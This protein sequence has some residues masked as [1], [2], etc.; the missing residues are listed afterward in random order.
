MRFLLPEPAGTSAAGGE[1]NASL[2]EQGGAG[3][4]VSRLLEMLCPG[5]PGREV[6]NEEENSLTE[7]G[8]YP[9]PPK[10]Y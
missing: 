2:C 9:P 1:R 8:F 10:D 4:A 6:Q 5:W 7:G 3:N